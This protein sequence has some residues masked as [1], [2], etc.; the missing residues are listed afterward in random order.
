MNG[1][2]KIVRVH[3]LAAAPPPDGLRPQ[4]RPRARGRCRRPRRLR[5]LP[6]LLLM[7]AAILASESGHFPVLTATVVLPALGAVAV[8]LTPKRRPDLAKLIGLLFAVGTFALTVFVLVQFKTHPDLLDR[9][10]DRPRSP[11]GLP[12]GRLTPWSEAVGDRL[13]PRRRRH[14]AV[15]RRAHRPAL[16][17]RHARRQAP[18]RPKAFMAWLLLLES[19]CLGTFLSLDLFLFFVMFEVVLVPMY[20]LIVGWGY[21]DR[22][23]AAMKFF[24]YTMLGSA[25][26]LV[27][28][29]RPG[30]PHR[31][32]HGSR[33]VQPASRSPGPR[34]FA[35][36]RPLAVPR[37]R[38]G[39]RREGAAVPGAHLAARRAHRGAHRRLGDPGRRHAEARHLRLPALRPLPV[40]RGLGVLRPGCSSRWV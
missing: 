5:P 12:D 33:H 19:G 4:L 36:H 18:P 26:M 40:P 30:V 20:F 29:D 25:F 9:R 32:A 39:L 34:S 2:G 23:Y 24:I 35:D 16:P 7:T 6:G 37:L 13:A 1:V 27:G 22:R 8:A 14:L 17:P 11:R 21:D 15:A 10:T 3:R 38:R 31:G 28:D